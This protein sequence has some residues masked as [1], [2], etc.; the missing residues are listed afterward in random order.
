MQEYAGNSL[1]SVPATLM[2]HRM[3]THAPSIPSA[4]RI[5][6]VEDEVAQRLLYEEE[7]N[8]E[9]SSSFG[10]KMARKP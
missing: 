3:S 2:T 5:L 1:T 6:L 9:G 10:Q 8:E 7:L 4:R